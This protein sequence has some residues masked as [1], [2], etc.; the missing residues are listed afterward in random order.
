MLLID[1]SASISVAHSSFLFGSRRYN[2]FSLFLIFLEF[3]EERKQLLELVG[4]E[5]QSIYDDM[6][7]E[8]RETVEF[9][10]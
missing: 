7:I 1:V 4:P 9:P 2:A 5:L 8:V 3:T 10:S 6:G